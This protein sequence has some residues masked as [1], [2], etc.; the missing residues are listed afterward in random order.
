LHFIGIGKQTIDC[1]YESVNV[2]LTRN[3]IRLCKNAGIK[4]IVYISGLGVNEKTTSGY[5]ISKFKA[6]QEIIKSGL[7]YTIFRASY[8]LGKNDLLSQ[9]LDRQIKRSLISIPGSGNY[10]LQPIFVEDVARVIMKSITERQFSKK[11]VDLVGP[12]TITYK[13][14]VSDFLQGRK[15]KIR[16]VNFEQAYHDALHSK[17]KEFGVDDL[18]ILAGDYVGNHKR[19]AKI[20]RVEFTKYNEMLKS[21]SLS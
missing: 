8:I 10:R 16:N 9:I 2:N 4:K 1:D 20:S 15:I 12:K 18:A 11:I 21:C 13:Q 17:N 19:L 3:A 5:F 6:E 14:F 7:D